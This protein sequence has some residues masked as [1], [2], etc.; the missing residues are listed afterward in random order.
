MTQVTTLRYSD[1][2]SYF[3]QKIKSWRYY[4]IEDINQ[5]EVFKNLNLKR[6]INSN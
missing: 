4:V 2:T 3:I 6:K 1:Y 5:Y